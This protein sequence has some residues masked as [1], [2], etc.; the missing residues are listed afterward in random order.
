MVE[1]YEEIVRKWY[2]RLRGDFTDILMSKYPNTEIRLADAENIYQDIFLAI[3]QNLKKGRIG[4]D[5][6]WRNYIIRVGLN[7]ASK[8]YHH[9]TRFSSID[10]LVGDENTE[11]L[12]RLQRVTELLNELP[13]R[14]G[15]H[16]I[17]SEPGNR[18][19]PT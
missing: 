16:G 5:C 13:P 17:P 10:E 8:R 11:R 1:T 19:D 3:H 7:M 18:G 9:V 14:G 6:D 15:R 4:N 12:D 2:L